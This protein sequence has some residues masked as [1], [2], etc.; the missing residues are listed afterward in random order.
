MHRASFGTER[1]L[2]IE[3]EQPELKC[4]GSSLAW[5]SADDRAIAKN[6]RNG[7]F[8]SHVCPGMNG[9]SQKNHTFRI[10]EPCGLDTKLMENSAQPFWFQITRWCSSQ[11][12][13]HWLDQEHT[14]A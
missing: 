1:V 2:S 10:R 9:I 8:A 12:L 5:P 11:V 14:T 13:L 6:K 4:F 7:R 3:Q